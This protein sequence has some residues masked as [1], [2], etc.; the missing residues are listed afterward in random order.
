MVRNNLYWGACG[1]LHTFPLECPGGVDQSPRRSPTFTMSALL[2]KSLDELR[3]PS[4]SNGPRRS[5][6]GGRSS[7]SRQ[8]SSPYSVCNSYLRSVGSVSSRLTLL[9]RPAPASGKGSD[10][11]QHDMYNTEEG[12][13]R[14]HR[15]P[16]GGNSSD[17]S[18][19]L[20]IEN[21]HYEVSEAELAVRPSQ[22]QT[23]HCTAL[24]SLNSRSSPKWA[25]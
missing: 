16:R 7:L 20:R 23:R 14:S 12:S 9:Q 1:D 3:K 5:R 17:A 8:D 6:G 19:K 18:N 10:S 22:T 2:D 15:E 25:S 4:K 13:S 11:W 24:T 21:L